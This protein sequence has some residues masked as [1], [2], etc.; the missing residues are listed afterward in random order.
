MVDNNEKITCHKCG[1][2]LA[3]KLGDVIRIRR[4]HNREVYK[5]DILVTHSEGVIAIPCPQC[6]NATP[7]YLITLKPTATSTSAR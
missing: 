7:A 4:N 6:I 2:V 5:Q 1:L 3:K